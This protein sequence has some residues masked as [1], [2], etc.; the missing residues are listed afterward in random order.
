MEAL[1]DFLGFLYEVPIWA[2]VTSAILIA[3]IFAYSG[4]PLWLWAIA[5]YIGIAG[6]DAPNWLYIT[7]SV[8]VVLFNV[9]PVR[10][11]LLSGP[12][13][14]L[15]DALNF[16]PT[17]SE[18]EQTA[19][20][21]GTVWV[22]GELFSGKPNFKRILDEAYPELT[23]DEQDFLDNQVEALCEMVNDWDVFVKKDFEEEAWEF[24]RKEGFFGLIVPKKFGGHEFSAT[25]HSAIVAKVG[26][27]CG[28]LAT[29]V[30]VPNSLGPAELLMHYGTEEQKEYY[31]P[32]LAAGV[33][34][35]CFALTEPN[36]GSDA[37]G[38]TSEGEVFKGEDGELYLKLNWNK[39]Y[40]TL[41]SISTVLGLAFK[42]K[43]PENLLG[44]GEDLGIT[45]ALIPSDT[46]GV[47]LGKRH[48]PL[49]VPFHNCPTHGHDVIV[50]IDAII[51]GK[52]GAGNGWRMLMESLAVG[53]GISLPAQSLGGA[54]MATRVVGA[55]AM[56][57]KQFGLNIGKFEGI[58]EP[59]ARI[60][61]YTYFM[62]AAR[63]Y[64]TGG[65]DQ[66]AKPAVVTAIMKYNFTE[67]MR[68][69][70]ND[71][72]DIVGGAGISRGPR[73]I[74]ANGYISLPIAITV[75][76][77][78]ILTRTLMI[79]GQ[80][81]IRCHPYALS[82]IK[83]L[84]EGDVKGFD[85]NFW[86]HIGHVGRNKARAFVLS[87]TRGA[88]ASS[89][90]S[91]PASKYFRRLAWASASFAFFADIALGSYGGALKM[92]EKIAGRYADILSH[93]YLAAATLKR[94]EAEGRRK[95][96]EA[97]FK[98]AMEYIFYRI[99][100]AFEG[101]L[102]EIKVPGLSWVFR[103]AGVWSRLNPIGTYPSDDLGHK[104]ASAIQVVGD[105]RDRI[106]DG[107]Y[108]PKDPEQAMGRYENALNLIT[109]AE[110]VYKKLYVAM[111]KKELPKAPVTELIGIALK[112]EVI[113]QEEAKLATDAEE[114]RNDAIQVDEF[115]LEEY[116][117]ETP[118]ATSGKGLTSSEVISAM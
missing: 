96:D 97:F 16:L 31:L 7:Y 51:G 75:E 106:T 27:R 79:F 64:T 69:I 74:F 14:K 57:R 48:D 112:K 1:T 50:P 81:A 118:N 44:K 93:M 116:M 18:T 73:N 88:L 26:S 49:G 71:G 76:G 101:I 9:K 45:C 15:M 37:G 108:V 77:A 28:P 90:V 46:K 47:V 95:E 70:V 40:I 94:F 60:G 24:L 29:T 72:M 87:I 19:I 38:M 104:V 55:Y 56:I 111:K 2:S 23:K 21:A 85:D 5:G 78:N 36:A 8:L 68:E 39:R 53:R 89:P 114:A 83:A 63:R 65:L 58:E 12:I 91:G 54:K 117:N 66:G 86:R 82:E 92:K 32:R 84:T 42:L 105:Q 4:A 30:M 43:D 52:E 6:L 110:P 98:W 25:A 33:E 34:M 10:R 13:M 99:Q 22:D 109:Q 17:I 113:T 11:T 100:V 35:P 41:A 59:M 115:T 61:G 20:D 107:I 62:E 102:K 103:L 80:G 67:L 3:V